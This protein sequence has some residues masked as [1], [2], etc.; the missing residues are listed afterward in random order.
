[1]KILDTK[2][3]RKVGNSSVVTLPKALLD[4]LNVED[5]DT[6]VFIEHDGKIFIQSAIQKDKDLNNMLEQ[7]TD[8]HDEVFRKLVD[9]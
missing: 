1:M 6:L 8:E 9:R 4:K 2:K 7:L 5:D 3:I